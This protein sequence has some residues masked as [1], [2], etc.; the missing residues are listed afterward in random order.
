MYRLARLRLLVPGG[1]RARAFHP[2]CHGFERTLLAAVILFSAR[3]MSHLCSSQGDVKWTKHHNVLKNG[4][5]EPVIGFF[6][7]CPAPAAN[8]LSDNWH[9]VI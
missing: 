9:G 8:D 2:L 7:D 5:G 3:P 1:A 4:D 6:L